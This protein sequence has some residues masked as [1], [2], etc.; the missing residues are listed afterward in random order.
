MSEQAGPCGAAPSAQAQPID[1]PRG[2]GRAFD[3]PGEA[4][5]AYRSAAVEGL[6]F[7]WPREQA[8]PVIGRGGQA[9]PS[10]RSAGEQAELVSRPRWS[11]SALSIGCG[12]ADP[13]HLVDQPQSRFLVDQRPHGWT[14][15]PPSC[16]EASRSLIEP[17][18]LLVSASVTFRTPSWP[19]RAG[20]R[21]VRSSRRSS[22]S[23]CEATASR[24]EATPRRQAR[25]AATARLLGPSWPC[26]VETGSGTIDSL[27]EGIALLGPL[28]RPPRAGRGSRIQD[29]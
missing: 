6:P 26:A 11:T 29:A 2:A 28:P 25:L 15:S 27:W 8:W 10:F 9:E 5:L 24:C 19:Q 12:G 18:Q 4:G 1:Q 23:R 20:D 21:V 22:A 17:V 3:R 13:I 7:D 14:L 16:L